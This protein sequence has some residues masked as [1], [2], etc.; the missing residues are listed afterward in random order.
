MSHFPHPIA[1]LFSSCMLAA[2]SAVAV[3]MA[4]AKVASTARTPAALRADALF[5]ST[6]HEGRYEAIPQALKATTAA[7]LQDP[8]DAATAAHV[9]WMHIWRLAESARLPEP[10]PAITDDAVL[11]RRYFQEA[12]ALNPGEARYLGFLAASQLAEGSIHQDEKLTRQGYFNLKAAI[13]AFPEFNLFTGGY[14]MS[15][16]PAEGE[17]FREGLE[18]Q[19]QTLDLCAGTKVDRAHPDFAAYLSKATTEGAKRVC[20]N[21]WIAPHNFEGFFLNM[22]DMLVKSGDW[23]TARKV[24]ANARHSPTYGGWKYAAV[25]EARIEQAPQNVAAFAKPS[26]PGQ[27]GARMM[28]GST[29]ACMAC[30]QQSGL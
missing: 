17:R 29:F 24:Y 19:W 28:F 16:Q 11:A 27:A 23:Q 15:H 2:C 22:G 10:D 7:Y 20:W 9:G 12:V 14:V 21:G 6:L 25:L 8:N 30:H 4:P 5:W 18:W 3:Q 26:Q 1:L 13:D